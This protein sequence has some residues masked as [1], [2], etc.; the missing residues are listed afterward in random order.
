MGWL[1]DMAVEYHH[2][3]HPGRGRH[4]LRLV[5]RRRPLKMG[6]WGVPIHCRLESQRLYPSY[7]R[8][9]AP[10]SSGLITYQGSLTFWTAAFP[11]LA[12][13]LPEIQ[14]SLALVVEGKKRYMETHSNR[15][16]AVLKL[17]HQ[18]ARSHDCGFSG[19]KPT[20]KYIIYYRFSGRDRSSCY[21][22]RYPESLAL[23]RERPGKH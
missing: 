20:V 17:P 19:T 12:R 2:H 1:W 6:N 7:K 15:A 23:R 14:E 16:M 11:G 5:R 18:H 21:H 3:F 9:K 4:I 22:G 10:F 8:L 13:N